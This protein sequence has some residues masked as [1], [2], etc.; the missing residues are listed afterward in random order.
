MAI[1]ICPDCSGKVSTKAQSCPHC[2]HPMA[3]HEA[4]TCPECRATLPAG[5]GACAACGFQ[6][7]ADAAPVDPNS[8]VRT[9]VCHNCLERVMGGTAR[10][11]KCGVDLSA[12]RSHI[13]ASAEL[14][15][16]GFP[17]RAGKPASVVRSEGPERPSTRLGLL[18]GGAVLLAIVAWAY[19][20]SLGASPFGGTQSGGGNYSEPAPGAPYAPASGKTAPPPTTT[21]TV[22]Y[23]EGH[24]QGHTA[25]D[26]AGR[27][28]AI[29]D[30]SGRETLKKSVQGL[31]ESADTSRQAEEW[32]RGFKE[33]VRKGYSDAGGQW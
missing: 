18:V 21:E 24:K 32:K 25:G 26:R 31:L 22:A 27:A 13:H 12:P 33:G 3:A 6:P 19:Y 7:T 23:S 30:S 2:G 14:D 9:A 8:D 20:S 5:S 15:A 4:P 1:T 10:C 11:P 29:S 28:Y 16:D 17:I